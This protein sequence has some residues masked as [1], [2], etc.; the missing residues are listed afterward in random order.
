[1]RDE[2]EYDDD[3]ITAEDAEEFVKR[4]LLANHVASR[5]P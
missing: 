2:D 4:E 1:L 3:E 5:T